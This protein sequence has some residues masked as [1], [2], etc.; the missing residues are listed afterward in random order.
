MGAMDKETAT[1]KVLG[2]IQ[3]MPSLSTTATKVLQV[4][5]TPA[6]APNDL[7]RVISLDPVLAGKV[8]KLINSAYYARR[9]KIT[10]L[11]RAIIMLGI[12]TIKNLVLSTAIVNSVSKGVVSRTMDM[13]LFWSHSIQVGVTA[14][15]IAKEMG[16]PVLDQEFFFLAGLMHDLGKIPM[17]NQFP[18][19]YDQ[20][21][22]ISC[23]S[24]IDICLAEKKLMGLTHCD[25][26]QM[27]VKKWDLGD[28]IESAFTSHHNIRVGVP[29]EDRTG[30]IIELADMYAHLPRET[31]TGESENMTL[32]IPPE[33]GLLNEKTGVSHEKLV[34][35]D[36]TIFVEME[37]ARAFLTI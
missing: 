18:E 24:R 32:P 8:L 35:F 4:C 25:I 31:K 27:I 21:M 6:P 37:N 22:T 34:T 17:S 20:A 15:L 5:N 3:Q 1:A 30:W 33:M 13:N 10:S 9:N 7:N 26:G 14:R 16:I 12:N 23:N 29:D 11:T 2:F 19:L 36:D 28:G